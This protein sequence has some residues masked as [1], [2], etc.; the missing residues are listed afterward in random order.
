[1]VMVGSSPR[2]VG[3]EVVV[4]VAAAVDLSYHRMLRFLSFFVRKGRSYNL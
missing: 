2:L 3:E 1:M 4:E